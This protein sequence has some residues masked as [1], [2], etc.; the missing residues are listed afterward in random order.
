MMRKET[1]LKKTFNNAV[2]NTIKRFSTLEAN[3]NYV[4]LQEMGLLRISRV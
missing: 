1:R 3:D 4:L 2:E